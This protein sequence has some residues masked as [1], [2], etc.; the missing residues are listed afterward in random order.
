MSVT[1]T[2]SISATIGGASSRIRMSFTGNVELTARPRLLA[3][4]AGELTARTDN[5]TGTVTLATGHGQVSGTYTVFWA[6]G[7]RY[8][9]TGVVTGD[10]IALDGGAGDNLPVLNTDV[11]I[12][13]QEE[14][15]FD[16][17]DSDVQLLTASATRRG[18][19]IFLEE[20]NAVL[21][22]L[23]LGP[24]EET[25]DGYVW[26]D[27]PQFGSLL[28]NGDVSKIRFANGSTDGTYTDFNVA[29]LKT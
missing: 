14:M 16:F 19:V 2:L 15:D 28:I 12:D 18:L 3:G 5:D 10:T 29:V 24:N 1:R 13:E 9:M 27:R 23:Q 17:I 25:N 26:G 11:V 8:N 20:T 4:K 21:Y 22:A 6:G 7:K